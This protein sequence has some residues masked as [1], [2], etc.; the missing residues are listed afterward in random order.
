MSPRLL[1]LV[2]LLAATSTA[3]AHSIGVSKGT[4]RILPAEG[5]VEVTI[6]L[7]D[8]DVDRAVDL[9]ETP[10]PDD[11]EARGDELRR[12]VLSGFAKAFV[13][14]NAGVACAAEPMEARHNQGIEVRLRWHCDTPLTK[15]DVALEW[16]RR[17]APGHRNIS[18]VRTDGVASEE[19]KIFTRSQ[20]RYVKTYSAMAAPAASPAEAA[21]VSA[22]ETF[23]ATFRWGFEHILDP[24]EPFRAWDHLLF[25]LAL[26]ALGG[27]LMDLLKIVTSFTAAHTISA[28][29]VYARVVSPPSEIVEACVAGTIV[30]VAVENFRIKSTQWRWL[31][32]FV[33]G[34]IH[35]FAFA[36]AFD[37]PTFPRG[38]LVT[39]MLTFNLGVEAGQLAVVGV[40]WPLIRLASRREWYRRWLL[41]PASGLA[42]LGGAF[43]LLDRTVGI[44]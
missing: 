12:R 19:V 42:A 15:L 20:L 37:D 8:N 4:W 41:Y 43:A 44:L 33:F 2:A 3:Q 31:V 9:Y 17:M 6:G 22:W 39:T 7:H 18:H 13:V 14:T 1:V 28:A 24:N 38:G 40:C 23:K 32:A 27:G 34:L 11:L 10:L 25:L 26:L 29:L 30:F 21:P 35:G 5:L 36:G 16:M